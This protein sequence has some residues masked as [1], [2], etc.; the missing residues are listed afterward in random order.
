MKAKFDRE[1]RE[2]RVVPE[3]HKFCSACDAVKPFDA[4]PRNRAD[5]S[6]YATY[7]KPCHNAR[8]RETKERLYGG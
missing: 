8:T 4:F 7:C 3:G 2:G 1:V 6:G 5:N